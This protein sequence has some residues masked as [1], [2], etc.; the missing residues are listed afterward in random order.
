[1]FQGSK[2]TEIYCMA[3]DFC[4]E[5]YPV[6]FCWFPLL[7]TKECGSEVFAFQS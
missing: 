3:D 4:K 1:M 2:V 6:P 5:F 7:Q